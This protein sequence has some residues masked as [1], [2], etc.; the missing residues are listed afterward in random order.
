M[1]TKLKLGLDLDGTIVDT[2]T[3]IIRALGD[4]LPFGLITDDLKSHNFEYL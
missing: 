3:A 1:S 4:K 2:P